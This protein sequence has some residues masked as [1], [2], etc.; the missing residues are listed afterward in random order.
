MGRILALAATGG[1]VLLAACSDVVETPLDPSAKLA[2]AAVGA[3]AVTTDADRGPGSFLDAVELASEDPAIGV[4][5]FASGVDPVVLR[6]PVVFSG[7][8]DLVIMGRGTR[9]VGRELGDGLSALVVE[10]GGDLTIRQL[11]VIGAPG[12]GVAVRVPDD[13][14]GTLT[15]RLVDVR[16]QDNGLHGILVNDQADYFEN[17]AS[18]GEEGSAAN[19]WVEVID[20][21]FHRNGFALIDSD[22]LRLNEGGAGTLEVL[23]RNTW[24]TG[25]GADGLELDERGAG[26]V[27]FTLRSVNLVGNGSFAAE[28]LDDGIDVDER[29][30][31]DLDGRFHEV[32]ASRNH[33]QGIDLNEN[34]AGDLRVYMAD[35]KAVENYEEG[36]EL[37]EDDDVE[38]GGGIDARLLRV[39]TRSNGAAGGDAGLKLR[40]KGRGDLRASLSAILSLD[41][42]LGEPGDPIS[43]SLLQEDAAGRLSAQIRES[44][45]SRNSGAGA[46]LAQEEPGKGEVGFAGFTANGNDGGTIEADGV[47]V[48]GLP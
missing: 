1:L 40:E 16:I 11:A 32:F 9:L 14:T 43:G 37:E 41:N 42:R 4:I 36:I 8:Q 22:G 38:G 46:S 44:T 5:R 45:T 13:A 2:E 28:D 47:E 6:S 34:G 18:E 17:P 27:E 25:N 23:V 7:S 26:D 31:G 15:V 10:G 20:S 29:G 24:F 21:R 12:N 39:T 48:R 35:V 3:A 33:E 30:D 19:V